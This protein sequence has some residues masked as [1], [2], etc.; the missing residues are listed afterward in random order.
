LE[1]GDRLEL[2]PEADACRGQHPWL[3]SLDFGDRL[4]KCGK[5]F[6]GPLRAGY[7]ALVNPGTRD[8]LTFEW[9]ARPMNWLGVWLTRGGWHGHHHLALEPT[10]ARCDSLAQAVA[11]GHPCSRVRAGGTVEWTVRLRVQPAG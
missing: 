2:P 3:A 1:P 8:R 6:I 10:N 9:A 4:E 11:E 5:V 7:A